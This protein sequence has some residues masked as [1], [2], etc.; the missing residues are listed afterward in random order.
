VVRGC[1]VGQNPASRRRRADARESVAL[2]LHAMAAGQL[3]RC[4]ATLRRA[5]RPM[6]AKVGPVDVGCCWTNVVFA[7]GLEESK[8][9]KKQRVGSRE[10][11]E[12]PRGQRGEGASA[13]TYTHIRIQ[14]TLVDRIASFASS[15]AHAFT[16]SHAP[17]PTHTHTHTHTHT[18]SLSAAAVT[19]DTTLSVICSADTCPADEESRDLAD[20]V[21]VADLEQEQHQALEQA[22]AQE[23]DAQEQQQAQVQRQG[24]EQGCD[25]DTMDE[26]RWTPRFSD[27]VVKLDF[28]YEEVLEEREEQL[29]RRHRSTSDAKDT[30]ASTL[31]S[32]V[33]SSLGSS[34]HARYTS[35]SASGGLV[36]LTTPCTREHL[37][38]EVHSITAD[39]IADAGMRAADANAACESAAPRKVPRDKYGFEVREGYLAEAFQVAQVGVV[40]KDDCVRSPHTCRSP[41]Q[42]RPRSPSTPPAGVCSV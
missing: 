15:C 41:T 21:A 39:M 30:A 6:P 23:R 24:K 25:L 1:G 40:G 4:V 31:A 33:A 32:A 37:E 9:S 10:Q 35:S 12:R 8:E 16:R 14:Y 17:S 42:A 20:G 36:D 29:R 22:H 18:L 5:H 34:G 38:Q 3:S 19:V 7:T 26:E 2:S 13:R 28:T 27:V 11:N